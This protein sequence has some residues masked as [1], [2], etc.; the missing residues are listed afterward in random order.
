M[1]PIDALFI[2]SDKLGRPIPERPQNKYLV[3]IY[4]D[5]LVDERKYKKTLEEEL[6]AQFRARIEEV[7]ILKTDY[8]TY[9]M[10]AMCPPTRSR[11]TSAFQYAGVTPMIKTTKSRRRLREAVQYMLS[12]LPDGGGQQQL[13][14]TIKKKATIPERSLLS[15]STSESD[16]SSSST[17]SKMIEESQSGSS[18]IFTDEET[19]VTT[20]RSPETL[21]LNSLWESLEDKLATIRLSSAN[22]NRLADDLSDS[23]IE[24][25]SELTKGVASLWADELPWYS[26]VLLLMDKERTEHRRL[27]DQGTREVHMVHSEEHLARQICLAIKDQSKYLIWYDLSSNRENIVDKLELAK[28]EGWTGEFLVIALFGYYDSPTCIHNIVKE[29][30]PK[31]YA[32][33]VWIFVSR[34]PPRIAGV[35]MIEHK[36]YKIKKRNDGRADPTVMRLSV[37]DVTDLLEEEYSIRRNRNVVALQK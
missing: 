36:F 13:E 4:Q 21:A 26:S 3:L 11:D 14:K 30:L 5:I 9:V 22:E 15:C 35:D 10:L 31:E 8:S 25:D 2:H 12:K 34:I 23:D 7:T 17:E 19:S 1:Y 20:G 32:C 6:K 37:R 24:D 29:V 18:S 16:E 33:S 28:E 27:F